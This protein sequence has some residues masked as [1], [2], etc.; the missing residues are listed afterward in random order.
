MFGLFEI[1]IMGIVY[2]VY[3]ALVKIFRIGI[4]LE[5]ISYYLLKYNIIFY[6]GDVSYALGIGVAGNGIY[7][8]MKDD[9]VQAIAIFGGF[10]AIIGGAYLRRRNS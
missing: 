8:Y 5:L 6:V 10:C 2:C 7:D 9:S 1:M 3:L 4:V